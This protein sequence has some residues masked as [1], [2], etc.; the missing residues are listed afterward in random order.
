M[1]ITGGL[2]RE[3]EI[4][5]QNRTHRIVNAHRFSLIAQSVIPCTEFEGL[6]QGLFAD[7]I[8]QLAAKAPCGIRPMGKT[9]LKSVFSVTADG[10]IPGKHVKVSAITGNVPDAV[11][12]KSETEGLVPLLKTPE[13]KTIEAALGIRM[14]SIPQD[15]VHG[16]PAIAI[17]K[18]AYEP[19]PKNV[20]WSVRELPKYVKPE[21]KWTYYSAIWSDDSV[22]R[23]RRDDVLACLR[24]Q[25]PPDLVLN[26]PHLE[27]LSV[28][29]NYFQ[30]QPEMNAVGY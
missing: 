27:R 25:L 28:T 23:Q 11:W 29:E 24:Q 6:A 15:P 4:K 3:Q 18:F 16:L 20:D 30:Q 22:F 13:R 19:I 26:E 7:K 9:N 2:L 21:E 12:G 17:E 8:A 1:R 10:I 5:G 14:V